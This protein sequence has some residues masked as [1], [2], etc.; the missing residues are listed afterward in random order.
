MDSKLRCV[1]EL[2]SENDKMVSICVMETWI[3]RRNGRI[4]GK[5]GGLKEEEH[6]GRNMKK[7]MGKEKLGKRGTNGKFKRK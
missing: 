7:W 1:F 5:K 4:G 6:R 2:P 3:Q